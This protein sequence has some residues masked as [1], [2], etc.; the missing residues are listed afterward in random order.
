MKI[1]LSP[2]KQVY[3][4]INYPTISIETSHEEMTADD[5]VEQLIKP[6]L[7]AWGFQEETV[8]NLFK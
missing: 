4:E 3:G 5:V 8:N 7:L 2:T 6:G 1:T